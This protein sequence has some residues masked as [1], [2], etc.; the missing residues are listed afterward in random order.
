MVEDEYLKGIRE[1]ETPT[2]AKKQPQMRI[3][4]E[5]EAYDL[6]ALK[7]AKLSAQAQWSPDPGQSI[8]K[9]RE[10]IN[11]AK[12]FYPEFNPNEPE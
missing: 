1:R 8:L 7:A 12:V 9:L 10:M 6:F 3:L 11:L 2:W 5:S 4:K